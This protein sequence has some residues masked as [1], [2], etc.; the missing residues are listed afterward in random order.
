MPFE[1]SGY[2]VEGMRVGQSNATFTQSPDNLISNPGAFDAFYLPDESAPRADYMVLVTSEGPPQAEPPLPPGPYPGLLESARFGWTKNEIVARFTYDAQAGAFKPLRGAA[3]VEV[4]ILTAEANMDATRLRVRP[5]VQADEVPDAPYRLSVGSSGSGVK[6]IVAPVAHDADFT[7]PP[8]GTVQ[9]SMETGN[10]HWAAADLATYAGQRVRFQQQQFYELKDSTG[11]LGTAPIAPSDPVLLLNP[12]P[13]PNQYPRLRFGYGLYLTTVEKPNEGAFT[14]PPLGTVQW[15]LDTGRLLFNSTD[16]ANHAGVPVYYDGVLFKT[17]QGLPPQPRGTVNLPGTIS[18]LPQ[19]GAS[20][21]FSLPGATPYYRFPS[22]IYRLEAD[23]NSGKKGEVQVDP[24]NGKFRFSEADKTEFGTQNVVLYFGDLPIERGMTVRFLRNPVNLAAALPLKDVTAIYTVKAA[25]WADPIIQSPQ[26]SLPSLPIEGYPLKVQVLQGQGFYVSDPEDGFPNLN[27][28]PPPDSGLGFYIDYDAGLLFFAERKENLLVPIQ[29]LTSDVVLPDPLLLSTNL[30]FELETGPGTGNYN[31]LTIGEDVI[32]DT[33]AGVVSFTS[34]NTLVVE[35]TAT[36]SGTRLTDPSAHFETDGVQAGY[37]AVLAN[38]SVYTVAKLSD[39]VPADPPNPA[40]TPETSLELDLAVSPA[41]PSVTYAIY[42]SREVLADRY[43]A[44]AVLL[45]PSTKVER[46]RSLGVASND[47]PRLNVPPAYVETTGYRLGASQSDGFATVVLVPDNAAFSDPASLPAGT[48]ELSEESGEANF[49]SA[50]LGKSIYWVI[51]QIPGKD[52]ELQP[53]LGLV[54]FR[55]RMLQREEARITYTVATPSTIPQTLPGPP[56]TEY[57]TFLIRKEIVEPHPEPTSVLSF[58]KA[59]LPVTMNPPPAV[60]RGGRPQALGV[61]CV[62]DPVSS[63]ITFLVDKQITDALPHGPTIAPD[64][65]VYIDYYV[66]K[67]VGGEKTFTVL[68]P[69][70]LT[71]VVTINEIDGD[72]EPNNSFVVHGDHE[73]TFPPGH[74]MRIENEQVYQIGDSNYDDVKQETTVVLAGNQVFQSPFTDPRIFVSSGPTPI[75]ATTFVPGYFASGAEIFEAIARGSNTFVLA[76]DQSLLYRPGTVVLFTND[77]A[78]FTDFLQVTGSAYEA[79]TGRTVVMLSANTIRQYVYGPQLLLRSVRPVFEALVTELQTSRVPKLTEPYVVYRRVSGEPGQVLDSPVDY[80][81]NGSGHIVFAEPLGLGEEFGI[82]Y[83]GLTTVDPGSGNPPQHLKASYTCQIAPSATNGLLGQILLADYS[84]SSPDT[85]YYR[86]ET[87]T[88]FR[89][90]FALEIATQA[91]SG[92]SGPQT[93]NSS[94]PKLWEQGRKSLYFDERHLFNQDVI[95]RGTLLFYND[96]VTLLEAYKTGLDGSVVGNNDGSFL[97]DGTTGH[98]V[99]PS[100]PVT[101]QIDDAIKVSPAPY[102]VTYP[103][104]AVTSIGTFRKYYTPGDLSRFF[105][106]Q[107]NFFGVPAIDPLVT[108]APGTEVLDTGA[109]NIT[110]VSGL[111]TRLAWAVVTKK[112]FAGETTLAVDNA[113]GSADY[114]HPQFLPGMLCLIQQPNGTLV[115]APLTIAGSGVTATSLT[116]TTPLTVTVIKGCTVYRSPADTS[117]TGVNKLVNHVLNRDYSFTGETGQ[118][119]YVASAAGN[120]PL[121]SGEAVSGLVSFPNQETAPARIPALYGGIEDDD[122]DLSFP[123]QTPDQN[124]ELKGYLDTEVAMINGILSLTTESNG[125]SPPVLVTMIETFAG[126]HSSTR[127]EF[128]TSAIVPSIQVFD[129]V[130]ITSGANSLDPEARLFRRIISVDGTGLN[131]S[132]VNPWLY[133]VG[134][135]NIEI[136]TATAKSGPS[137]QG[138]FPTTTRL[139]DL[140]ANFTANVQVGETVVITSGLN[141]GLRRQ[142]K[143]ILNSQLLE[144][145]KPVTSVIVAPAAASSY[146]VVASLS[147]YGNYYTPP[148]LTDMKTTLTDAVAAE[149]PLY[150]NEKAALLEVLDMAFTDF[151]LPSPRAATVAVNTL[152]D[153]AATFEHSKVTTQHV[154]YIESGANAQVYQIKKVLD[155]TH[156]ETVEPFTSPGPVTYRL[157][158]TFGISGESARTIYTLYKAIEVRR[159]EAQTFYNTLVATIAIAGDTTNSYATSL[160]DATLSARLIRVN[161]RLAEIPAA[162]TAIEDILVNVDQLYDKRYVWVD[163]RI[164]LEDGLLV[165]QDT[166]IK[167][168]IKAQ[169]EILKQLTKLLAVEGT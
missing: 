33:T 28:S 15:A 143:T 42:D 108:L 41:M 39:P 63:Q 99:T 92:S 103:P 115:G 3:P 136:A 133:Q 46:I 61:Q 105:P 93:S 129:I 73:E 4:G 150:V 122:G 154:I 100:E 9:L 75:S 124:S 44:P 85:F 132:G 162:V 120:S 169:A 163:A 49:A 1:I 29:S 96:M 147:S 98:V 8:A 67:A 71:S 19:L 7:S 40:I 158:S 82:I 16:A 2:V 155:E 102:E 139:S 137:N 168:R 56:I 101:N 106:T 68:Q 153:G 87:M 114:V 57:A 43:F 14:A 51:E 50:D 142:V 166:A 23:F 27:V 22:V 78:T 165:R 81:I 18:N 121:L 118:I 145:D 161:S 113:N 32:V 127:I 151:L 130:R 62:V 148:Y 80:T 156:L 125:I 117:Q 54:H 77:A 65:R 140:T 135:V 34:T 5:P 107:R 144:L 79:N 90:E 123:I 138:Y 58:N 69:P 95:A 111:H 31:E 25:T 126:S 88:Q 141:Q 84:L 10:L 83:T 55:D 91:S 52:Y 167:N 72:G 47:V 48:V 109:E 35:G 119:T 6:K 116:F 74:L 12:L 164:N 104:F 146:R 30:K 76:G 89:A 97:F 59:G 157:V 24:T 21:I 159:T 37:L 70:I 38:E 149:I 53:E 64:E 86:V 131:I 36:V 45:D 128:T 160:R 11:K 66:T 26:V 134:F 13:G 110:T 60:F 152:T 17:E 20:L 112:A 94:Q